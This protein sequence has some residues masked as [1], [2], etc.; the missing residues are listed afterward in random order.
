MTAM[1]T[2]MQ[3]MLRCLDDRLVVLAF[4]KLHRSE[5][6]ARLDVAGDRLRRLCAAYPASWRALQRRLG[7]AP[8]AGPRRE[9]R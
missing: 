1:T 9:A 4:G 8:G 7:A 2:V 5:E 6:R 3:E